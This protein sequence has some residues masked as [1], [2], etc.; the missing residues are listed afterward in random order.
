MES[1]KR[2]VSPAMLASPSSTSE[3][4]RVSTA[5]KAANKYK[6]Q[7]PSFTVVIRSQNLL[8]HDVTVPGDFLKGGI[9]ESMQ[10][11]TLKYSDRSWPVKLL[12]YPQ[13]GAGKLSA[14]FGAFQRGTS[15]K[16]G[17]VCVFELARTDTI[18]LNV[19]IFRKNVET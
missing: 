8:K 17:D 12:Y 11:T 5:L 4:W 16:E 14:G 15:L 9:N 19:S 1:S 18:E 6:L 10:T 7:Y 3:R 2:K 13:H